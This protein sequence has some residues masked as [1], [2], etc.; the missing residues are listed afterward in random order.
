[1]EHELYMEKLSHIPLKL[2]VYGNSYTTSPKDE[3]YMNFH[4]PLINITSA[5]L[6]FSGIWDNFSI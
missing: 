3:W 6:I 1:M 4:I 2:V 5:H